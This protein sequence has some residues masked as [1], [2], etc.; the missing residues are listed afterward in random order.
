MKKGTKVVLLNRDEA[1]VA[2][3]FKGVKQTQQFGGSVWQQAAVE[4]E[5]KIR[6][7]MQFE[8][9]AIVRVVT[10]DRAFEDADR[11][12]VLV[13]NDVCTD[14]DRIEMQEGVFV[15]VVYAG[16]MRKPIKEGALLVEV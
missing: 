8:L 11:K 13:E 14:V 10:P 16:L 3:V 9:L 1:A 7:C 5:G 15:A 6:H 4:V 2:G 12:Y